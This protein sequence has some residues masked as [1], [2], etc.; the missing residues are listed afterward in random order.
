[1]T[2]NQSSTLLPTTTHS[3]TIGHPVAFTYPNTPVTSS[4]TSSIFT[5]VAT[6]GRSSPQDRAA[7]FDSNSPSGTTNPLSFVVPAL[8]RLYVIGLTAVT[9]VGNVGTACQ[10]Y[11]V[12]VLRLN[13][14]RRNVKFLKL[15][16][17][18]K[19]YCGKI[20]AFCEHAFYPKSKLLSQGQQH[21]VS[22]TYSINSSASHNWVYGDLVFHQTL[23]LDQHNTSTLLNS[24]STTLFRSEMPSGGLI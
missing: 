3:S 11:G 20:V 9:V 24:S 19:I 22:N 13:T 14:I 18:M 8:L 16:V 15:C 1:M 12:N 21:I 10:N 6:A 7:L 23:G 2:F 5:T 4:V 17:K